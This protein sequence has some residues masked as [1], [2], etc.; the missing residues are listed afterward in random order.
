LKINQSAARMQQLINDLLIFSRTA[1]LRERIFEDINLNETL[2]EVKEEF[3]EMIEE[4]PYKTTIRIIDS[5]ENVYINRISI[6]EDKED[7]IVIYLEDAAQLAQNVSDATLIK[8]FQAMLDNTDD[9]IYFKDKNHIFITASK[10]L[11]SLT[12]VE[13]R[14][15]FSGKTDYQIFPYELADEYFKLE[16]EVFDNGKSVAQEL[17]P[18]LDK[19]GNKAW[20]DNRKYPIYDEHGAVIGL[21]GIARVIPN[22]KML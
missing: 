16:R 2:E 18:T 11:V 20:V 17:Q 6:Y 7:H 14:E 3:Q 5:Y 9:Y 13:R 21:F 4:K 12:S 15:D 8:A 10:S 22:S 19:D 1:N